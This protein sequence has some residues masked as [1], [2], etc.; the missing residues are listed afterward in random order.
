M[1]SGTL[2]QARHA[3]QQNRKLFILDSCFRKRGLT[4]PTRFLERGAIR[5][6]DF[7]E[8]KAHLATA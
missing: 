7:S 1:M 2:I 6:S 3:L 8:I 4:W 5:V